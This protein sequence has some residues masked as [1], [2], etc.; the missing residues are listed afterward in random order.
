MWKS[1]TP[2][3]VILSKI[4]EGHMNYKYVNSNVYG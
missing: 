2:P 3:H 4:I 1:M